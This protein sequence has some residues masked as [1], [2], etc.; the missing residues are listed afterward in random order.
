MNKSRIKYLDYARVFSIILVMYAHFFTVKDSPLRMWIYSFH[1]PI[2][3]I[4]TGI[5]IYKKNSKFDI[6]KQFKNLIVPYFV[7]STIN[8]VA[9]SIL[10]FINNKDWFTNALVNFKNIF[11]FLGVKATWFLPC[12]F[13]GM[14]VFYYIKE[15]FKKKE[16]L[17]FVLILIL[18]IPYLKI[19]MGNIAT[20]RVICRSLI[21][22]VFIFSGY[23]IGQ[24]IDKIKINKRK[25]LILFLASIVCTYILGYADLCYL[26]LSDPFIYFSSAIV[27]SMLIILLFKYLDEKNIKLRLLEFIGKDSL[28]FFGTHMVLGYFVKKFISDIAKI[29][30]LISNLYLRG[31]IILIVVLII[32]ILGIFIFNILKKKVV[33]VYGKKTNKSI[34]NS[35]SI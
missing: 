5:L 30:Y 11:L 8:V 18:L 34:N 20:Y 6:K 27:G 14:V 31:L 25:I 32:E 16:S 29:D 35:S 3:F 22:S 7:L 10:D 2:F 9:L 28:I 26:E 12:L 21:A 24:T 4:I 15:R 33:G 17:L 23:F 13:I 19:D 1:V